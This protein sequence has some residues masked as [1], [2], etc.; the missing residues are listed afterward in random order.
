MTATLERRIEVLRLAREH[1]FIILEGEFR[2]AYW[3]ISL[4]LVYAPRSFPFPFPR[5]AHRTS[6]RD[7]TF[8]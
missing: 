6:K 5:R 2:V 1:N 3:C 7:L 8:R 4:E